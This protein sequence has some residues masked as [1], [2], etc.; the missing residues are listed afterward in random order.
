[1]TEVNDTSVN[2][3]RKYCRELGITAA[4]TGRSIDQLIAQARASD[5]PRAW[6]AALSDAPPGEETEPPAVT[7]VVKLPAEEKPAA[8]AAT[9]HRTDW[10]DRS[11]PSDELINLV[12]LSVPVSDD[13][14]EGYL[15]REMHLD[16]R[17]G[18]EASG[19]FR[20]LQRALNLT[21]AR[22][23][24]GRHVGNSRADV[25]RWVFERLATTLE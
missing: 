18:R 1:M 11:D 25:I 2:A 17:L 3:L 16:V 9:Q 14:P 5:D 15:E 23:S 4:T 12:A 20:R 22:L 24:N 6:L 19:A 21:D 7:E 8:A 13:E 10:S